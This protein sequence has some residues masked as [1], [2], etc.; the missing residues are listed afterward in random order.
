MTIA[1]A[2]MLEASPIKVH[3]PLGDRAYDIVVGRGLLAEAGERI[4]ALGA[5][6]A[7]IVTDANVG[8]LYAGRLGEIP[9]TAGVTNV[10]DHGRGRRS[11]QVLCV[12]GAGLRC[13]SR[14]T[15][16]ARRSGDRAR[17]GRSRRPCGLRCRRDAARCPFRAD[18]HEPAVSGRFARS[19]ARPASTRPM[20]RIS[21]VRFISQVSSWPI[22]RSST[23]CRFAK[24]AQ[25]M[26]RW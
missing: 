15:H 5:R 7:A 26:P 18:S 1:A 12:A 11:N 21:S 14:S 20:A 3:V 23:R 16:R 22:R 19:A 13:G 25:V 17:R 9:S 24:C 6:A 10:R 4:A 8:A 2:A